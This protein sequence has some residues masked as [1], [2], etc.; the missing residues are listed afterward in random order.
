[1][2]AQSNSFVDAAIR[3]NRDRV[4]YTH[5]VITHTHIFSSRIAINVVH[6]DRAKLVAI[7][8]QSAT[9]WMITSG[10]YTKLFSFELH[11]AN[12][13]ILVSF[14]FDEHINQM[15]YYR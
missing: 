5:D 11:Q 14:G 12:G 1:M 7:P 9:F 4:I 15:V 10:K 8:V 13:Y 2:S 3:D 6:M